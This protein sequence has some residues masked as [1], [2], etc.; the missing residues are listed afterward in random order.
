[1]LWFASERRL[2]T[3]ATSL[4]S[5]TARS[6]FKCLVSQAAQ[7][8]TGRG[9]ASVPATPEERFALML[10]RLSNDP[11]WAQEYDTY[12]LRVSY[13]PAQARVSF[14]DALAALRRLTGR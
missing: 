13:A 5:I 12:V 9:G 8:D 14:A 3:H 11:L 10:D 6:E 7:D 1:M 4:W 2:S